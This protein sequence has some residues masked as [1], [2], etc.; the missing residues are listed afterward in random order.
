MLWNSGA[1][2]SIK[3]LENLELYPTGTLVPYILLFCRGNTKPDSL[4]SLGIHM[5]MNLRLIAIPL[6][7]F[8]SHNGYGKIVRLVS[9]PKFYKDK[10]K[11]VIAPKG[12]L[13]TIITKSSSR[14]WRHI[15]TICDCDGIWNATLFSFLENQEAL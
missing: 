12:L 13:N 2:F 6:S 9:G 7:K 8:V 11:V 1:P 14:L 5:K 3:S 4:T 10:R 15:L